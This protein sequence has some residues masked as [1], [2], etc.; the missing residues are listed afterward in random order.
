M[1]RQCGAGWRAGLWSLGLPCASHEHL[2][3]VEE[4]CYPAEPAHLS[5]VWLHAPP[6]LAV[7]SK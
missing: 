6:R 4:L 2:L 1:A 7:S 3:N 5:G